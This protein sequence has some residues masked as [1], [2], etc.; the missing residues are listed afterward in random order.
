M[1]GLELREEFKGR[2]LKGTAI[3][4]SNQNKTGAIQVPAKQFLEITYPSGDVLNAIEAVGPDSGRPVVLIGERGQGKSHIM[5]VLYHAFHA[6]GESLAWLKELDGDPE[7]LNQYGGAIAL[8]HPVGASGGRLIANIMRVLE[9]TNGRYGLV[10]MCESGG[11]AN[12]TLI[13]NLT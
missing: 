13:E 5:G 7:K 3:E 12:A 9:D 1:L 10:T 2:R 4:L 11:M 6:A 8:G